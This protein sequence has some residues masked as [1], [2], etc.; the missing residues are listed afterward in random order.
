MAVVNEPTKWNKSSKIASMNCLEGDSKIWHK[1]RKSI[2]TD[3]L[4][5]SRR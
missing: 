2:W 1:E 3:L 4:A 5:E